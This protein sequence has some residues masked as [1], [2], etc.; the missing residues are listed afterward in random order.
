MQN[1]VWKQAGFLICSP[2]ATSC[3]RRFGGALCGNGYFRGMLRL[4]L[5]L[6]LPAL[7][8]SLC[9]ATADTT[10]RAE[11][12]SLLAWV[13]VQEGAVFVRNGKEHTPAEAVEHLRLKWKHQEKH[14]RTAEDFILRC[15]TR[16]SVTGRPYRIRFADGSE[17]SSESVLREELRK[18]RK[19]ASIPD[20]NTRFVSHVQ[21]PL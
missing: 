7:S 15:A 17:R 3:L 12:E 1:P 11:I 21:E 18:I 8:V 13:E 14:V 19:R 6:L 2:T 9:F 4:K 20:S 5:L 16:S 10:A